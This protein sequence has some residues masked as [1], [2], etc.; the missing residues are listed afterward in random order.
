VHV[1]RDLERAI[2]ELTAE[3]RAVFVLRDAHGFSEAEVAHALEIDVSAVKAR[4]HRA[5]VRLRKL[6]S[7]EGET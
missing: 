2:G 7:T 4:L 5:R 6:L 3:Q 1:R